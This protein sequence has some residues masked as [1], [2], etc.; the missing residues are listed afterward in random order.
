MPDQGSRPTEPTPIAPAGARL[1]AIVDS[2][3]DAVINV[4]LDGTILT[5]N[6]AAER[7][8][9]YSAGEAIGS[10]TVGLVP[11]ALRHEQERL[12]D[13]VRQGEKVVRHETSRIGRD[14]R[15]IPVEVSMS[16]VR[17]AGGAVVAIETIETDITERQRAAE[18]ASRLSAIVESS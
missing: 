2:V 14:G 9:G 17:D 7:M 1:A 3:D 13:K 10:P 16:P 18:A 6:P 11:P 8:F 5:W 4:A 12:L 15:T